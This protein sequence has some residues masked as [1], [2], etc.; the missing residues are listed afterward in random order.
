MKTESKIQ[1]GQGLGTKQTCPQCNARFYDLNKTPIG[2]PKCSHEF[3]VGLTTVPQSNA[4]GRKKMSRYTDASD[5][6]AFPE[7]EKMPGAS[8]TDD[9]L[10]DPN[11][12]IQGDDDVSHMMGG[13]RNAEFEEYS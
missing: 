10:E 4:T 13:R 12:L 5:Y 2:C 11:D 1:S 6:S 3:K 9:L 8:Y 7:E